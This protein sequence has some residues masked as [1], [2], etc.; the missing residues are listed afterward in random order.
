[1]RKERMYA[2]YH[3]SIHRIA[4]HVY[5]QGITRTDISPLSRRAAVKP[6]TPTPCT[7]HSSHVYNTPTPC[8]H[9][10]HVYNTDTK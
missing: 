5:T 7:A 3:L 6:N 4:Y 10:F 8:T 9:S 1:M 2:Q